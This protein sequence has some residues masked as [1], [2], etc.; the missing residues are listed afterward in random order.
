MTTTATP[1][2]PD[3]R[4]ISQLLRDAWAEAQEK[5]IVQITDLYTDVN[6]ACAIG[7]IGLHLG[8]KRAE[9]DDLD[10]HSGLGPKFEEPIP[11]ALLP[12]GIKTPHGYYTPF[13]L[14][15]NLND[16]LGW[17]P[18]QMADYFESIGQ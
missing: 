9:I 12:D 15:L 10:Y 2:T 17:T 16:K 7:M 8:F 3:A 4:P 13:S 11:D 1:A 14:I 18:D 5:G 6:G